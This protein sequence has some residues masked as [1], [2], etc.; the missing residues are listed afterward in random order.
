M[1]VNRIAIIG[2]GT[3]G[4]GIAISA[5]S[6][7]IQTTLIDRSSES[8]ARARLRLDSFLE[9]ATEKGRIDAD[10]AHATRERLTC[11]EDLS[12]AAGADLVI[13]AVFEKLEIKT[14]LLRALEPVVRPDCIL[15][16]NTSCLRVSDI[17][18]A[19]QYPSRFI[20]LHYFAPA[21]INPVVEVVLG[22][23]TDPTLVPKV[24]SFLQLTGKSALQCTDHNGFALN[25]FFCPYVNE[26]VRCL[27]DGLGVPAQIDALAKELFGVAMGPFATTNIVGP[28]VMLHALE[29]LAHLG[30]FYAPAAALQTLVREK[31]KWQ[32]TS[33]P[34]ALS[35]SAAAEVRSRLMAA[36]YLPIAELLTERVAT[37]ADIDQGARL[38]L[39]FGFD[40]AGSFLAMTPD[41]Q[42]LT[43]APMR[44]R[45]G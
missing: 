25:R 26:A 35:E 28:Q 33:M 18:T 10:S 40:P 22:A 4:A 39:R 2:S 43:L 14:D 15:A 3:M 23:T 44:Q 41:Q 32:I 29:N 21:E 17:A 36:I 6:S 13:E 31:W 1:K 37:P 9:R 24:R 19:L 20:G 12:G 45:H 34:E 42:A 27:E 8:L 38:A 16:T 30:S 7:G 5:L 11:T